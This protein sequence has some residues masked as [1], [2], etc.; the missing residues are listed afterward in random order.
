MNILGD[1]KNWGNYD[2]FMSVFEYQIFVGWVYYFF[3]D[4]E[5][6][7]W[8]RAMIFFRKISKILWK[9]DNRKIREKDV[10]NNIECKADTWWSIK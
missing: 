3:N 1:F 9:C 10:N 6:F 2:G 7:W 8:D 5:F 4:I